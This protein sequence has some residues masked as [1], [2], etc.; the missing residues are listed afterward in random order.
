[1]RRS[2]S[3][4]SAAVAPRTIETTLGELADA[5][6]S[7]GQVLD[8]RLGVRA[9]YHVVKLA[10]LVSVELAHYHAEHRALLTE[11]GE[12]RDQTAS[13]TARSGSTDRVLAVTSANS[14]AF[15]ARVKTLRDLPVSLAWGPIQPVDLSDAPDLTAR[16]ILHLGPLFDMQAPESEPTP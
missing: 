6:P 16:T 11:L 1:M 2:K 12:E 14:A 8:T 4:A 13:E 9:R 15:A 7:L 3:G 10:R 5:E